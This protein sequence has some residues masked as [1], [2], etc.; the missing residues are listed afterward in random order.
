MTLEGLLPQC[1]IY[2]EIEGKH[3]QTCDLI[4]Y[5]I[6]SKDCTQCKDSDPDCNLYREWY[7]AQKLKSY[8]IPNVRG[9][10]GRI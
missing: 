4:V 10:E 2:R 8:K 7:F 1:P 3:L 5:G 6:Q 9:L